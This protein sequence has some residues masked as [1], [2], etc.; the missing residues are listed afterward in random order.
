[1]SRY[2][3]DVTPNT[4][5]GLIRGGL[6]ALRDIAPHLVVVDPAAARKLRAKVQNMPWALKLLDQVA[7]EAQPPGRV[8]SWLHVG[9]AAHAYDR[10]GLVSRGFTHI[11]VVGGE[12]KARFP[13]RFCYMHVKARD[14][15][16]F[17]LKDHFPRIVGFLHTLSQRKARGHRV[18]CLVHCFAGA[19]R[20]VAAIVAYLIWKGMSADQGLAFVKKRR[21]AAQPNEGFL[22]QVAQWEREVRQGAHTELPAPLDSELSLPVHIETKLPDL[23]ANDMFEDSDRE[24]DD[25][26]IRR[27]HQDVRFG[28]DYERFLME[29][30]YCPRSIANHVQTTPLPIPNT[31]VAVCK[32]YNEQFDP[33]ILPSPTT[34]QTI[35]GTHP[36]AQQRKSEEFPLDILRNT[37]LVALSLTRPFH[38]DDAWMSLHASDTALTSSQSI[39]QN[40]WTSDLSDFEQSDHDKYIDTLMAD[41]GDSEEG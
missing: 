28:P 40:A 22:N 9:A 26:Y 5:L 13:E 29:E 2:A 10:T 17:P 6:P 33:S 19:S 18:K 15:A 8:F 34:P 39:T 30:E 24:E 16:T 32:S 36:E 37:P 3:A 11:L 12:L 4:R 1:M 27:T 7:C 14:T 20:S 35:T 21:E 31:P 25:I 38:S 23:P 41:L